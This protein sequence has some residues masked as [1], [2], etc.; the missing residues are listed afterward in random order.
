LFV[1]NE[2]HAVFEVEVGFAVITK[3]LVSSLVDTS[4]D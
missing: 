4:V 2:C 1:G 3:A